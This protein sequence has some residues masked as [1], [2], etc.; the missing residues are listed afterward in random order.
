MKIFWWL[1]EDIDCSFWDCII[2]YQT[3][4]SLVWSAGEPSSDVTVS[5]EA[6]AGCQPRV[7]SDSEPRL[8]IRDLKP[9]QLI[10]H[11]YPGHKWFSSSHL[12]SLISGL[13][14]YRLQNNHFSFLISLNLSDLL[15]RRKYV[16]TN[17]GVVLEDLLRWKKTVHL[18]SG[19]YWTGYWL[20][21]IWTDLLKLVTGDPSNDLTRISD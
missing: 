5:C 7:S 10:V 20:L 18:Q 6:E 3:E 16:G 4:V 11:H 17:D 14:F 19:F 9:T 12:T 1:S 21:L 2:F 13:V 15:W 8:D